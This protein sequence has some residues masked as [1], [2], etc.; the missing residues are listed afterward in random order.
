VGGASLAAHGAVIAALLLAP[1]V[2][3]VTEPDP[4]QVVVLAPVPPPEREPDLPKTPKP[5][6][7]P[8]RP[9]P[10]TRVAA[11]PTK[12]APQPASLTAGPPSLGEG[13]DEL[14][15]TE[16][17]GAAGVGAGGGTG[18]NMLARLQAALRRD[19]RVREAVAQAG[20]DKALLVWNGEWVRHGAQ[21]GRGLAA[22]RE[23]ILWEVGF[24]P[25]ACR[26]ERV[27]GLVLVSLGEGA[28]G[29]RLVLGRG[30]WRWADVLRV[31][32]RRGG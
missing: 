14:S 6:P 8:P 5:A 7:A 10:P 30:A 21:D 23:A 16:V 15:E 12:A 1:P 18:C 27:E 28:G 9:P 17:A 32:G 4:V 19:A 11:R 22:V 2:T 26:A 31:A 13:T 25:P 24:A 29:G 3:R 20:P